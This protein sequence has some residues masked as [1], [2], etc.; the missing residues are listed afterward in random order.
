[1]RLIELKVDGY[2]GF[3]AGKISFD[4]QLTV[5]VGENGAG[6]SSLLDA[7]FLL[8]SHYSARLIGASSS[9]GRL[10]DTDIRVG[11]E[12]A[13]LSLIARDEEVG[14]VSW[15]IAK[16]GVRQRVLKPSSSNLTGLNDFAKA[17]AARS[18]NDDF[19][20]G[21]VV[22][23][24]YD[25]SRAVLRIPRRRR[26]RAD[27]S[28]LSVFQDSTSTWG[29]NF[30]LLTY[31]FQDRETDELRRQKSRKNYVDRELDAV[32]RA[33]TLATELRDPYFSVD[34]PRGLTF[35][36]RNTALHVSQLSTGEQVFMALAGDLARRL[37]AVAPLD[38][39]P[40][41]ANA[42]VLVDEL[43]LHLHPRWQRIIVPW[44]LKTFPN[45]QFIVSTHSPQVVS[46]VS[47][48]H[49]R[50]LRDTAR[51]TTI[52]MARS[53]LGRD[54]NH[55]LTSVFG[56]SSRKVAAESHI[57]E[58]DRAIMSGKLEKAKR[59]IA[60]LEQEIEGGPPEVAILQARLARRNP[61]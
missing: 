15:A 30:P 44:L 19:L 37:A 14:E 42:I 47:A 1:M 40:L 29:I 60:Q 59:L 2:R 10:K 50:I 20:R 33:I 5:L 55:L 48:K 6:K 52:N 25:Q 16:Q 56:V 53:T 7:L 24:Y 11:R 31:W 13:R 3:A 4:R 43:E 38:S 32:R 35:T 39:D 45:C 36:K 57:L 27:T 51:G 22:P 28:A 21:E 17:V 23:I 49:V 58:A 41:K 34:R 8:L 46:E 26:T 61:A 12:E 9:A 18:S 54:S